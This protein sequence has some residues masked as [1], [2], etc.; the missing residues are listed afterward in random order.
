MTLITA[1]ESINVMQ[2]EVKAEFRQ[3]ELGIKAG[4]PSFSWRLTQKT[5]AGTRRREIVKRAILG[6]SLMFERLAVIDLS[7]D[8]NRMSDQKFGVNLRKHVGQQGETAASYQCADP[9]DLLPKPHPSEWELLTIFGN[10]KEA[11][12]IESRVCSSTDVVACPPTNRAQKQP[13]QYKSNQKA[14]TLSK[15]H[16][17]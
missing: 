10:T 3:S 17:G 12:N 6:A 4:L 9:V 15:P 1:H 2:M 5:K 7:Q 11:Y 14:K 13:T 16:E 8:L